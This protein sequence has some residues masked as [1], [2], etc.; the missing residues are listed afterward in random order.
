MILVF[1]FLVSVGTGSM[2][3]QTKNQ[4]YLLKNTLMHQGSKKNR[5][6]NHFLCPFSDL[7]FKDTYSLLVDMSLFLTLQLLLSIPDVL[8][9]VFSDFY[10]VP[11]LYLLRDP[12]D[13]FYTPNTSPFLHIYM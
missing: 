13:N 5:S 3:I 1:V 7:W 10:S 2:I 12:V 8:H 11:S 6:L 9:T 4:K